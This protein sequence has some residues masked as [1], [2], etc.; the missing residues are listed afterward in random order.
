MFTR[1]KIAADRV[2]QVCEASCL[3]SRVIMF[4]LLNSTTYTT[5]GTLAKLH[6]KQTSQLYA[7]SF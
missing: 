6:C 1:G 4:S 2:Q 5:I 3:L 7:V